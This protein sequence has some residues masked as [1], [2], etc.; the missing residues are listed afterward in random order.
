MR[1]ILFLGLL[2][3]VFCVFSSHSVNAKAESNRGAK[4]LMQLMYSTAEEIARE[5]KLTI[6]NENIFEPEINIRLGTKYI[7]KLLSKYNNVGLAGCEKK[8]M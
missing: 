7:S 3:S 8:I 4:G 1:K 2:L 5:L 6:G